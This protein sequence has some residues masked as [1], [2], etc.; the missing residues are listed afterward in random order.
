MEAAAAEQD[1][2]AA[3]GGTGELQ[4]PLDRL[5][6]GAGQHH[7][8]ERRRR[9]GDQLLGEQPRQRRDPELGKVGGVGVEHPVQLRLHVRVI[10][11]ER[12]HAVAA[13]QVQVAVAIA[14]DQV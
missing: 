12:E 1:P 5:R 9:A 13:E 2:L 14:I 11:P 10:A 6:A 3:G 7:G 8:V 4:R